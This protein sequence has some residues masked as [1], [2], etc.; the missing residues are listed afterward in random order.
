VEK[1]DK[2][3]ERTVL[4]IEDDE[5]VKRVVQQVLKLKNYKVLEAKNSMEATRICITHVGTIDIFLIDVSVEHMT[6][7]KLGMKLSAFRPYT[8]TLYMSGHFGPDLI[9]NGILDSKAH[10]LQKPIRPSEL[11]AKMDQLLTAEKAHRKE[12]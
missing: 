3:T 8:E 2:L 6:G 10:F 1:S 11:F 9:Q 4:L 12:R 7:V 5:I